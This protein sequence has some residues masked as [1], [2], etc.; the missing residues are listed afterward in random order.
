MVKRRVN[1]PISSNSQSEQKE[2]LNRIK[3]SLRRQDVVLAIELLSSVPDLN[4]EWKNYFFTLGLN[5]PELREV[6]IYLATVGGVDL[7]NKAHTIFQAEAKLN[8]DFPLFRLCLQS[9][10]NPHTIRLI[11]DHLRIN[12]NS[13]VE[14]LLVGF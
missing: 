7:A 1:Q 14:E 3:E 6:A 8:D 12:P 5:D 2:I 10:L 4:R 9:G 13:S 11:K